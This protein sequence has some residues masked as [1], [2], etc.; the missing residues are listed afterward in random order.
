MDIDN[1]LIESKISVRNIRRRIPMISDIEK[2]NQQ[3]RRQQ[4]VLY[5]FREWD[6][7]D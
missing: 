5:P 4:E 2:F 3:A 1:N 7:Q 6:F